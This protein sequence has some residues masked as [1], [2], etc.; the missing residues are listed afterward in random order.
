KFTPRGGRVEVT[1]ERRGSQVEVRVSDTGRGIDADF[2]PH[3]FERF[4]QA[5]ASTSR[6]QPGLGI[7]LALVR[8]LVELHGGV[9][10]VASEGE[11][12]GAT[13]TVRLPTPATLVGIH[14]ADGPGV[15][16]P[17]ADP[18]RPLAG[19]AILVVDDDADARELL[20]M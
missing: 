7:G 18:F 10:D 16:G 6:S 14:G 1:L 13:F 15:P 11:G 8:H 17:G 19:V 3:V 9:V 12:R 2:L 20:R 4:S 5:E